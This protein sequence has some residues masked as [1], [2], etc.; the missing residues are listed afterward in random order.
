MAVIHAIALFEVMW[1]NLGGKNKY[2]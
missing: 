1:I 2:Y